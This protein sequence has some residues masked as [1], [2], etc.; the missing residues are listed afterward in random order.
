MSAPTIAEQALEVELTYLES[1]DFALRIAERAK[2][3]KLPLDEFNKRKA[4]LPALMAARDTLK[5]LA[6]KMSGATQ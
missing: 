2:A 6:A 1:R 5:E 3:G 4:R